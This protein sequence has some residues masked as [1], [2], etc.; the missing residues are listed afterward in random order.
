MYAIAKVPAL[1]Q[2]RTQKVYNAFT[3][4]VGIIAISAILYSLV[5]H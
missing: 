2:Y 3:V 1:K 4:I 5:Q